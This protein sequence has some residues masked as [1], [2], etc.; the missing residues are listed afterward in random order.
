[1][2]IHIPIRISINIDQRALILTIYLLHLL[3]WL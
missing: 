3:G 1:V 2:N